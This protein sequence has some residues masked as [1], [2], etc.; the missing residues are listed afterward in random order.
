MFV[1]ANAYLGTFAY[2][3]IVL[4]QRLIWKKEKANVEQSLLRTDFNI[5]HFYNAVVLQHNII[6]Q[7]LPDMLQEVD[8]GHY[9]SNGTMRNI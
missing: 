5:K 3:Y 4:G 1:S 7:V 9:S 8:S 6:I 2:N